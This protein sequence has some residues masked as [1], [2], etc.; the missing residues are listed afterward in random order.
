MVGLGAA[1]RGAADGPEGGLPRSGAIV[2]TVAE[3]GV[4]DAS[5]PGGEPRAIPGDCSSMH[6]NGARTARAWQSRLSPQ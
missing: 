1:E 4:L 5:M 3:E 6:Q 2:R